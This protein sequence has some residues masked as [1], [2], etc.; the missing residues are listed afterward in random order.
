MQF[1]NNWNKINVNRILKI[2]PCH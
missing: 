2:I 1:S